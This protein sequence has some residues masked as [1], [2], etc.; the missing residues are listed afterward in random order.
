MKL[1]QSKAV[2]S[3]LCV[4][5]LSLASV[6]QTKAAFSTPAPLVS[7]PTDSS[8]QQVAT[9]GNNVYVVWKDNEIGGTSFNPEIYFV[10]S[11][12]GGLT[13]EAPQNMSQSS[14]TSRNPRI[15]A[16]GQHVYITFN[17]GASSFLVHSED[18]GMSF[19]PKTNLT[20]SGIYLGAAGWLAASGTNLYMVWR[21]L[22]STA[23]LTTFT[24]PGL[25][26]TALLSLV[27][28]MCPFPLRPRTRSTPW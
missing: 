2:S 26:T 11:T 20:D 1:G 27:R 24:W 5:A 22:T 16:S 3:F 28:R 18:G 12:N 8:D 6:P 15:A 23:R 19:L 7:T 13:F 10:R 4:A 14:A 21:Q 25:A 9:S 17:E